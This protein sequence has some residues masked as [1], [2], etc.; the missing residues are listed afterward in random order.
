[1][2]EY[3]C[4]VRYSETENTGRMSLMGLLAL[5]QD[6][7]YLHA[8]AR[9][10]GIDHS[11]RVKQTWYLLSWNIRARRMPALSEAC[12][13]KTWFYDMRGP[14]ARKNLLLFGEDG[15]PI[16]EGDTLWIYM[17]T[18]K[19]EATVLPEGQFPAT[20]FA[21]KWEMP[22]AKRRRAH[23]PSEAKSLPDVTVEDR[24][25]DT[26]RHVNNLR[27]AEMAYHAAHLSGGKRLY[28]E[29]AH[30]AYLGDV[31][32]PLVFREGDETVVAMRNKD[33]VVCAVFA[34]GE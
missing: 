12:T 29:Y 27:F 3:T 31:L 9:G 34:F 20:D 11:A 26:N 16:A 21:P 8:E 15:E 24:E 32:T 7:G 1:M 5:F 22:R 2:Y 13:V 19:G 17:D 4:R 14:F 23:V 18:E 28:A 25:V 33:G 30:Q 6:V 10:V